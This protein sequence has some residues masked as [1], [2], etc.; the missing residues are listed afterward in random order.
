MQFWVFQLQQTPNRDLVLFMRQFCQVNNL[1]QVPLGPLPFQPQFQPPAN[2]G[3]AADLLVNKISLFRQMVSRELGVTRYGNRLLDEAATLEAAAAQYRD[4][5]NSPRSTDRQMAIVGQNLTSAYQDVAAEF[6]TVPSASSACQNL[7]WE[8]SRLVQFSE[9]AA[10]PNPAQFPNNPNPNTNATLKAS[11]ER[12]GDSLRQFA[13]FLTANYPESPF[14]TNL[15]RDVSGMA[16]QADSLR[17]LSQMPPGP[18]G[19][20]LQRV[21]MALLTQA[22]DVAR[23]LTNADFRLQQG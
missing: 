15:Y 6:R 16:V 10:R 9:S 4:T 2:P 18:G 14:N 8:I 11:A 21:A 3:T 23:Q 20:D 17:A 1:Q 12:L 5:V 13:S 19:A 22:R 7:L